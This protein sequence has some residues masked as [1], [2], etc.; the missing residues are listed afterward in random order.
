MKGGMKQRLSRV[1]MGVLCGLAVAGAAGCSGK[2]SA[3]SATMPA[4]TAATRPVVTLSNPWRFRAEMERF[5]QADA[6]RMPAAGGIVFVGSSSVKGWKLDRAFG[7][8][9]TLNRGFGGS[10]TAD[11]VFFFDRVVYRYRPKVVV[12]FVG[13]NDID[14]GKPLELV[15]DNVRRFAE[16]LRATLPEAKLVYVAVKPSPSRPG[17]VGKTREVNE[18]LA[19]LAGEMGFV[20]VDPTPGLFDAEGQLREELY[21]KDKLHFTAA[22]Y[23]VIDGVVAPVVRRVWGEVSK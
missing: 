11:C 3:A 21:L 12:L 6:K 15:V 20:F 5:E 14:A 4:T 10:H 8:L 13:S 18:K 16:M 2:G 7:D 19:A 9:P 22:G 17:N 1:V 23:E